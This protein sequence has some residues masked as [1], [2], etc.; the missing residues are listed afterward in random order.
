MIKRGRKP[1]AADPPNSEVSVPFLRICAGAPAAV[2]DMQFALRKDEHG[3]YQKIPCE[4]V[5]LGFDLD[6]LVSYLRYLEELHYKHE[7]HIPV[8]LGR[9]G[10]R[11]RRYIC[12]AILNDLYGWPDF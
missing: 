8:Y 2:K 3:F 12:M 5:R 7:S 11:R 9:S 10:S 4:L 1:R 6:E